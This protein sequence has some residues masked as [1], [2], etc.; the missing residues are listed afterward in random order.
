MSTDHR[1]ALAS[2]TRLDQLIAYLR[3]EMGWPISQDS[4]EN[5]DDLFFD[6]TPEELG[7]DP[8]TAAKI[9]SIKRL[10][11]LSPRQPW[12]IFFVE[13]EPKRL[14]VV[15]LRRIL[16]Q[17]ALKKRA[18]ANKAEQAAWAVDDLL[19]IS[20]FGKG[21]QRQ[22]SFAHFSQDR[23]DELA[24]LRVLGWDNLD[25]PL[26]L[27]DLAKELTEELAWP[28][29]ESDVA[30]WRLRWAGAFK[31]RHGEVVETSKELAIRLSEVAVAIRDR[32]KSTLAIETERG[33]LTT[34][35][36]AFREA[37]VHDLNADRFADMYA[38][39]ITYGL[40]SARIADPQ[41]RT[42][43]DFVAHM[44][45]NPF[46]RE[47]ME[48]F[49][50]A[51]GRHG[52]A[53]G[54]GIDFDELGVSEVVELLDRSKMEAVVRDFGDRNRQDDPVIY[55]YELFLSAYDKDLKV[56]RGV[57]YTPQPVVSYIVRSVHELLQTEFGLADGLAD[58]ST[59]GEVVD[60]HA[61]VRLP[62]L[63]DDPDEAHTIS[64]DEP[65]VQL[66]DPAT[67]TGTFL[68]EVIDVIHRTMTAKWRQ[69][70]F[71]DAERHAAWNTYVPKDLLPRLHAYELM[72]A[73]YAIAHMRV[74]L[75]LVETGYRFAT[76]ERA[77][78]YLTNALEPGGRQLSLSGFDALSHEA[79]AVN[80][81]K[82]HKRFTI[83]V[84][85]PPYAGESLNPSEGKDGRPTYIGGLIRDYFSVNGQKLDERNS[86]WLHD[87][88][89]KFIRIAEHLI[90]QAGAGVLG[91]ITNHSFIFN[92]TFRGM[93]R[94]LMSTF[95]RLE[96]SISTAAPSSESAVLMAP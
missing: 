29:D 91:Y 15:A 70:G 73:P 37:L 85:N 36:K 18:S 89:A 39:T 82:R 46:L 56:Q 92:A 75:K 94:H 32:I 21:E 77:R 23:P 81:I 9:E 17:V 3:D 22:I 63:T 30:A 66:L 38:Q 28:D 26:H 49:L 40:L 74:G 86:K 13:F 68:I 20:N 80:E 10:R 64:L 69:Q 24:T 65:F 47:L 48:T 87:D 11:P 90:E 78:I 8:R 95:A 59:W 27:D 54:Q 19:F 25:T 88:Y 84:G 58:T 72:M 71:S 76:D 57:F 93:R 14:P 61:G 42:A 5:A 31:V 51:G 12:G 16:S 45:T 1:A 60:R 62:L 44:R 2:I 55:F 53:G 6:F 41:K 50:Q 79:F 33:P 43:E 83:V 34:L 35:M 7:V 4:F 67:G 96:S 52:K